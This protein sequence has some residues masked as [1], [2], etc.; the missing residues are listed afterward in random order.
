MGTEVD[1]DAGQGL[2]SLVPPFA[3]DDQGVT[4]RGPN[5]SLAQCGHG[6][7][8]LKRLHD[9][10]KYWMGQLMNLTETLFAEEASQVIDQELLTEREAKAYMFVAKSVAPS[11]YEQAPSW[12]HALAVAKLK[13]DDDQE[14]WLTLAAREGWSAQKLRSEIA[15]AGAEGKTVMC[16]W[17]V[18]ACATEA[19]RDKLA[20]KLESEGHSVKR[21]E[22]LKK[23]PK[24][25]KAKKGPITAKGRKGAPAMNTRRRVPR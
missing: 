21:Q 10:V 7:V 11:V 6:L 22:K 8:R 2:L 16:F 5:P 17:L 23:I 13:P 24:P 14:S 12:E 19:K 4:L 9:G 25:K 15:Q 18:V 20:D 3:I 1:I